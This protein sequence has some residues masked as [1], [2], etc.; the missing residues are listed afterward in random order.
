[1][2]PPNVSGEVVKVYGG[3]T[4]GKD[5][6]HVDEPVL[7]VYNEAQNRTHVLNIS[8]FWP[9]RKPRPCAE[10]MLANQ[11]S[12]DLI[13]LSAYILNRNNNLSFFRNSFDH[14]FARHWC[15]FP[16]SAGRD[17]CSA[18][19]L[20]LRKDCHLPISGNF[21]SVAVKFISNVTNNDPGQVLQ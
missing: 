5:L 10:K 1:M 9:V 14:W 6:F 16:V 11:G 17:L 8:H 13:A 21:I 12:P 18:R 20:R 15:D 19:C 7:E 2:C 3:G 4:D